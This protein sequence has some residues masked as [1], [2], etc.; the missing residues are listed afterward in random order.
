MSLAR[1][2]PRL[3]WLQERALATVRAPSGYNGPREHYRRGFTPEGGWGGGDSGDWG[4]SGTAGW[5]CTHR[6][7]WPCMVVDVDGFF[8]VLTVGGSGGWLTFVVL[9]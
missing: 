2:S 6:F 4:V 3:R 7:M 9:G 1:L 8:G 5:K